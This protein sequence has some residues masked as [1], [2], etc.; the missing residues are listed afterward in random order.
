M[1]TTKQS[2]EDYAPLV[3]K[4]ERRITATITWLTMVERATLVG[5]VVSYVPI[6]MMCSVKMHVTNLKPIDRAKKHG[7]W[8]GSDIAGKGKP[9]VA[10]NK[11]TNPKG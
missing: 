1:G 2:V 9:L 3:N 7:L 5:T 11:V 10:W 8:R 6:Y 4:I